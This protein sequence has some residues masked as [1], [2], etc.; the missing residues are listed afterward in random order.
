MDRR[1]LKGSTGLL[2][3]REAGRSWSVAV[4]FGLAAVF[5]SACSEEIPV[6]LAEGALPGEPVTIEVDIPWSEFA[7]NLEVFGGYGSPR[8]LQQGFI[9]LDFADTLDARTLLRFRALPS[10]ATVRDTTGATRPDSSLAFVGAR[11]VAF[12][13]T[14]AS[15]NT[16][17]VNLSLRAMTTQWDP[18]TASWD[19][20]IDTINDRRAWP[21]AGGG[22]ALDVSTA[23]WDPATGD[24]AVFAVDSATLAMWSDTTDLTAGARLEALDPGFRL[25][26]RDAA[27]RLDV[28]PSLNPD[29][30]IELTS[31]ARQLTFI[32]SPFPSPPP[33]GV[34][35]GG[36]P[37]WR[38]VIDVSIPTTING[39]AS[40]CAVV[41]CP[42]VLTPAEISSAALVLTSRTTD[43]AFQPTDS[44]RLDVRPVYDRAAMP[45]S[46]LG[47]SLIS[48][49]LGSAVA[50]QAF[51]SAPGVPIKVI[52]TSFARDLLRGVDA[53]GRVP[54]NS[55]VLLSVFEPFSISFASFEGPG[56]ANEPTLRL[57]LTIGPPVEHP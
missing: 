38:T 33:D 50:P 46:P 54:P 53:R 47:A 40:F 2:S 21:E 42:H 20:A 51:G 41:A 18:T 39:P 5:A 55:L 1:H 27:L 28:R 16:G 29:T 15:T 26:M 56:G 24:S 25:K 49:L 9:A 35:I 17:P 23:I 34:R 48:D 36:A 6:G 13:D 10:V 45:K 52:F 32:Y 43:A 12:F 7:S 22:P 4:V 8:D 14:L 11:L 44:V 3:V 19:F 37:A 57:V 30:L 31:L